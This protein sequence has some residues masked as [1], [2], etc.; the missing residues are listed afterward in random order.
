MQ[1]AN[2]GMYQGKPVIVDVGF[3]SNVMQQYYKR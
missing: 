3:N 2:W 1:P